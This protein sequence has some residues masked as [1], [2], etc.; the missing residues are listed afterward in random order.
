MLLEFQN[1]ITIEIIEFKLLC[2]RFALDASHID[3]WDI[4]LLYADLDLVDT[5]VSSKH[6]V[7]LQDIFKTSSRHV[8]KMSLRYVFKTSYL[9][10]M[11]SRRF[12]FKTCLQDVSRHLLKTSWR[13]LQRNN[14][15]SSKTSSKGL[16]RCIQ[17]VFKKSW[18]TKKTLKR[19]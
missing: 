18:K 16:G 3:L 14:F 1:K 9:Q 4:D 13:R 17:D 12:V 15:S 5:D 6:F 8:S 2:F 19:C 7:C 11:S 10:D